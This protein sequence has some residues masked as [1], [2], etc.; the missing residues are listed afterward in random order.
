VRLAF[1]ITVWSLVAV[2][3]LAACDLI[4]AV[5]K[6][7]TPT[8][9]RRA[10]LAA[11][12]PPESSASTLTIYLPRLF[13][14]G[15]LGLQAAPRVATETGETARYALD[16]LIR[17]P[18]GDERAADFQYALDRRT[19]VLDLRVEEGTAVVELDEAGLQRV[20]G[21][22]FSELVYWS[23]VFT[24]TEVPEVQRVVL[25]RGGEPLPSLGDPPFPLPRLGTREVAP[26]W[27]RP[28]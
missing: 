20:H 9:V 21:R 6:S 26:P 24:L 27:A 4:G 1:F 28:R 11:P 3:V 8:R 23:I 19:Q 22:P 14:D 13:D 18:N 5:G 2:S 15:S 25:T 17:G 7:P 10:S 12:L 16:A